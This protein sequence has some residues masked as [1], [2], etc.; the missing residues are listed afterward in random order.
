MF[1]LILGVMLLCLSLT[2]C[3]NSFGKTDLAPY[4]SVR[5]SGYNGNG[6]AHVDFDFA[7]FEYSIMSGWKGGNNLEKLSELTAVEMT[8]AYKA[9]VSE[10][11][12]NGDKITVKINLD[13]E[14]ARK[15]GYR[16]TGLEKKFTVEGLDEAVM[17]DPFDEEHLQ[18]SVNGVSPFVDMEILYIGSRTEPHAHITY[19][20]DKQ[21]NLKNGDTVTITATMSEKYTKKGY[22]LTRSEMVVKVEGMQSYITDVSALSADDVSAIRQKAFEYYEIQKV[23]GLN[24][25]AADGREYNM[26]P[27]DV[28][29]YGEL[30]FADYGYALV[31]NGWGTN[32][33]LL[34]PFKVDV[35]DG[36]FYWWSGDYYSEPLM[37]NFE[38]MSGYFIISQLM[39]DENGQLI[40]EDGFR[41]E[42]SNL[43][44]NEQ[45]MVQSITDRFGEEGVYLGKFAQ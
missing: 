3:G 33:M 21:Y 2:A 17:I 43:Y 5:Y 37:K 28:G 32:A 7:D 14:L 34:I 4:L 16:F 26:A 40:K 20:A 10:G 39:L 42:M 6:T 45:Q 44:E 38:K 36:S 19:K 27:K 8:I 25:S 12:R 9:D 24:I 15:Y 1:F 41:W 30:R 29:S 22:A 13:E 35:Q 31:E 11:L 23:E 18:I